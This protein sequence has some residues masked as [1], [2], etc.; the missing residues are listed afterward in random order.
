MALTAYNPNDP[1]QDA[2]LQAL[3]RGESGGGSGSLW[4]GF[5]GIDLSNANRDPYGFPVWGGSSTSAG[6]THAAGTYQFQPGTWRDVASRYGLDFSR[7][8]DQNAGAWYLAE[9]TYYNRT[10]RSLDADLDAGDFGRLESSLASIWPSVTGNGANP[11]GLVAALT[12][13]GGQDGK[14]YGDTGK[15]EVQERRSLMDN[16]ASFF[17]RGG[18]IIVGA[19]V[20]FVA[21]WFILADTGVVPSPTQVAKSAASA[22]AA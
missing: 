7:Q 21:L 22:V 16:V 11:Q 10:G 20:V 2:F 1:E 14:T 5:G 18:L 19:V 6:P 8:S 17:S 3:A 9:E 15:T 13:G 4:V 12:G